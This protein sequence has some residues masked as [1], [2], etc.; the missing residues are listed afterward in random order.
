MKHYPYFIWD[1]I[2]VL[3][4]L[5]VIPIATLYITPHNYATAALSVLVFALIFK[6]SIEKTKDFEQ[7]VRNIKE[8]RSWESDFLS[9]G[10]LIL[11][12]KG[13]SMRYCS[14]LRGKV[15]GNISVD[16]AIDVKNKSKKEF[17]IKN[18][19]KGWLGEF[20][21]KG[22]RSA[23]RL[24]KEISAFN[25]KYRL[26]EIKNSNGLLHIVVNLQFKSAEPP[27]DKLGDMTSFLK[28][29]LEFSYRISSKLKR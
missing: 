8:L 17:E 11:D 25:K 1:A 18:I 4:L 20:S 9:L 15:D 2:L 3:L 22:N 16:Y 24:K 23:E 26:E 14:V 12:Y 19:G 21:V 13:Q 5:I 6:P 27:P 28:D 10:T 29:Y 7:S